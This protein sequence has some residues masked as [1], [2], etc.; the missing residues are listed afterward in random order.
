MSSSPSIPVLPTVV[1]HAGFNDH[2][3]FGHKILA[4]LLG[5]V[6]LAEIMWLS[7]TGSLPTPEQVSVLGDCAVVAAAADPHSWPFKLTRLAASFGVPSQGLAS[8]FAASPGSKFAPGRFG[9]AAEILETLRARVHDGAALREALAEVLGGGTEPF[10]VAYRKHDERI[11]ALRKVVH[12]RGRGSMQYWQLAEQT[13]ELARSELGLEPHFTFG[14]AA[15]ALDAGMR[16]R[17]L[18]LLGAL[19]LVPS[20][21]ANAAESAEQYSEVLRHMP[22]TCVRYGGPAPRISPRCAGGEGR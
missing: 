19:L 1:G 10:G 17:E 16:V 11:E 2:R 7:I 21:I 5:K 22:G 13:I 18:R 20:V 14:V 15:Y 12:A 9:R 4:D 8:A 6:G 3:F